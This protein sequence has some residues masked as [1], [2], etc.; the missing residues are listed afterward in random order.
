ME[1]ADLTRQSGI[2]DFATGCAT[3]LANAVHTVNVCTAS[4]L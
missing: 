3:A 4:S 1:E 2:A